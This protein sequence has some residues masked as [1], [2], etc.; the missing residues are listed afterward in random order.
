MDTQ[1]QDYPMG[2]SPE[3]QAE[4]QAEVEAAFGTP[5]PENPTPAAPKEKYALSDSWSKGRD[6]KKPFDYVIESSGQEVRVR[7]IDMGDMLKLGVAEEMD[8]MT[9]ALL[10]QEKPEVGG[11]AVATA[12]MKAG[13]FEKM[14][15]MINRIVMAGLITPKVHQPPLKND[16]KTGELVTDQDAK[17]DDVLY[18]DDIP[19]SDRME[20]F[21]VIFETD[22]LA[23]F[24]GQQAFGLGNVENVSTVSLPAD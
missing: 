7:R 4:K 11:A 2:E 16:E 6:F 10:N 17:K 20:L 19:F 9:K 14:E 15:N 1:E 5:V 22:G 12:V 13:N 8:F 23:T 24:R 3:Y 21:S 18:V